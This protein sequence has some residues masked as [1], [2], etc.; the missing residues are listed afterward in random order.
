MIG[1]QFYANDRDPASPTFNV[2]AA[3]GGTGFNFHSPGTN[4]LIE[5]CSFNFYRYDMDIEATNGPVQNITLRRDV[6]D[7]AWGDTNINFH[8]EG[9]YAYSVNNITLYQNVFDHDGWNTQIAEAA[10]AG[11]NH[12]VYFSSTVTGVDIEQNIF[13]NASFAGVI[14]HSGGII[15]DNLFLQ[16]PVAVSYGD[17]NGANSTIG[18]VTGSLIGNVIIG[19]APT[20][21][22]NYGQGFEVGNTKPGGTLVE[23]NI[24]TQDTAHGKP[25]IQLTMAVGTSNPSQ[26]VGEN[27]VT[28]EDNITNGWWIGLQTDASFNPG[29][30]GLYALNDLKVLNNDFMN[31]TEQ[32]VRHAGVFD[33]TQETFSGNRYY[34]AYLTQPNWVQLGSSVLSIGQWITGYDSTGTILSSLP[35]ADPNRS[36]ATYDAT[37]GGPGAL[38]DFLIQAES[39]SYTNY[40]PQYVAKAVM[41]YVQK[42]FTLDHHTPHRHHHAG[43][44]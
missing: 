21:G 42:G 44:C 26:C 2:N 37:V 28:V 43:K 4:I 13:A 11:Y 14:A 31:A 33:P 25:A 19:D 18:G 12:D 5:D 23:N 35:Y 20:G 41:S 27:D 32:V 24:F 36:A 8:S 39:L 6:I 1:I 34:T 40:Q 10:P 38:S 16:D 7:N 30:S 17:A 15:N 29:G 22:F 3:G 9:I